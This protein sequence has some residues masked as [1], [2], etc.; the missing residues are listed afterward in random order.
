MG[1]GEG[2]V[3]LSGQWCSIKLGFLRK[4]RDNIKKQMERVRG[5]SVPEIH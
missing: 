3:V 2:G 4:E 1:L 5:H